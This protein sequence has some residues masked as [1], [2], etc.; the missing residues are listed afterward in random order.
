MTITPGTM[1]DLELIHHI[2]TRPMNTVYEAELA[3]RLGDA[4]NRLAYTEAAL[5][6]YTGSKGQAEDQGVA[7]GQLNLAL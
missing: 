5:E 3:R 7:Q 6:Q 4:L 1:T 2:W